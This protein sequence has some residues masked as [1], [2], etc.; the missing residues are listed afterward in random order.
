MS[1][2]SFVKQLLSL[3]HIMKN[4]MKGKYCRKNDC[5]ASWSNKNVVTHKYELYIGLIYGSLQCMKYGYH[6]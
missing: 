1:R 6:S 3:A 2:D 5:K 4:Q